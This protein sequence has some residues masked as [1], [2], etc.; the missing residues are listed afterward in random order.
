MTLQ[1]MNAQRAEYNLSAIS[2]AEF[3]ANKK[4]W[5][6]YSQK[7]TIRGLISFE[8]RS[9]S[10]GGYIR[11]INAESETEAAKALTRPV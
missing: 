5:D 1:E 9:I 11:V 7:P 6:L 2:E 10:S 4:G 3:E 8:Y